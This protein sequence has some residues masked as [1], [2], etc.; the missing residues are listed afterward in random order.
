M[1]TGTIIKVTMH[2]NFERPVVTFWLAATDDPGAALEAVRKAISLDWIIEV[3]DRA[4]PGL[5]EHYG[6]APGYACPLPP[7]RKQ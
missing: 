5:V 7:P 3:Y 6:L 2:D 4:P 1:P